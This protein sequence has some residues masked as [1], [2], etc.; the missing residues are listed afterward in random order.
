MHSYSMNLGGYLSYRYSSYKK[1]VNKY[2]LRL[3]ELYRHYIQ[4]E[5]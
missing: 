3:K 1:R 2:L 5:N 4:S